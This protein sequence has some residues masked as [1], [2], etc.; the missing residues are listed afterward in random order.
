MLI[1]SQ[2]FNNVDLDSLQKDEIWVG[3]IGGMGTA[4]GIHFE[5]LFFKVCSRKGI[6]QDQNHPQWIY[7][8]AS[9]IPDRTKA[10]RGE[11]PDC[12]P[13]LVDIFKKAQAAGV[14]AVVVTCNTAH[15]YYEKVIEKVPIPWVHLPYETARYVS[16]TFPNI[17]QV[18]ILAS[19]GVLYTKLYY[20]MFNKMKIE[21]LEPWL[22]S[23]IQRS[24]MRAIYDQEFGLKRTGGSVS[25]QVQELLLEAID[26]LN[27]PLIVVG[28]SELSIAFAQ[29]NIQIPW[30]DPMTIAAEVLFDVCSG[31]R[32]P[33]TLVL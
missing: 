28:C 7:F 20:Q 27:A 6:S 22:D 19:D 3:V 9:K 15:Y 16:T 30:V 23:K 18:G 12:T 13:Y 33:S 1:K 17:K 11:E 21:A 32:M 29:M 4:A 24:I 5:Q 31:N 10:I 26:E 8:N 2:T 14:S 25:M